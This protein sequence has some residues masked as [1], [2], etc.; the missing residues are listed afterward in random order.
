[1]I[2][3][4]SATSTPSFLGSEPLDVRALAKCYAVSVPERREADVVVRAPEPAAQQAAD[5]LGLSAPVVDELA[6]PNLGRWAGLTLSEVAASEPEGLAAWTSDPGSV[7][8]GGESLVVFIARIGTWMDKLDA[9]RTLAVVH[10]MTA[11]AAAAHALGAPEAI[12]H[13]DV[14]PL[15][16]VALTRTD[17][18]RLQRL[19]RLTRSTGQTDE[20]PTSERAC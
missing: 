20:R 19:D 6:G 13:V 7:P 17:C 14:A 18:W 9:G 4:P 12:M 15:A 11:R 16:L 10:A 5:A 8:H 1:M 2:T 3:Y